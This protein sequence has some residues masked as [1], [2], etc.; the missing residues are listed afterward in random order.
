MEQIDLF[1]LLLSFQ[2]AGT[3]TILGVLFGL[4]ITWL[5]TRFK[6]NWVEVIDSLLTLP[7]VLPPTVLGY[8]LLVLLGRN[9]SVGQLFEAIGLPLVFSPRGAVIAATV[10]SVP[11]FI[12]TARAAMES[13]SKDLIDAARVLGRSEINIL[14]HVIIPV[15]WRGIAS[16]IVLMFARALGDFGTTLMV[17]GSIPGVTTTMPIAIY[18]AMLAGDRQTA[19]ILV[20]IMTG[21]AFITLFLL[22]WLNRSIVGRNR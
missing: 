14:V 7:M 18:D 22:N 2:V 11:F 16:G 4:P 19:N 10:V 3:A 15:A 12:K 20:T 17:S 8:Y 1:P 9:S 21:A 5:L 13:V 6:A